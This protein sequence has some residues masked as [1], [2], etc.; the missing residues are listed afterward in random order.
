MG[1][2][3]YYLLTML[4]ALGDPGAAPPLTPRELRRITAE[5]DGP[6]V[7]VDTVLLA[8]DLRLRDA[9]LAGE[10]DATT[11]DALRSP[12]VLGSDQLR[13]EAPL[14][15]HLT[16]GETDTGNASARTGVD[17][18]WEAYFRHA[19]ATARQTGSEFLAAWVEWEVAL[20]NALARERTKALE[21]VAEDYLVAPDLAG[22]EEVSEAVIAWTSAANPLDGLRALDRWRW[23]WLVAHDAYFSF[24]DDEVAAYA[25]KLSL[26][27]RWERLEAEKSE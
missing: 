20:R 3:N 7:L 16:G 2:Q 14:P 4:P 1:S 22:D 26:L 24:A 19:A 21:L 23:H 11:N 17:A 5:A 9:V 13:G 27:R 25:A 8:D 15:A 12:A 10:V 18:V 6:L